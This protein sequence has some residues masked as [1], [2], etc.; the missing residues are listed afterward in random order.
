MV[1]KGSLDMFIYFYFLIY[2][3]YLFIYLFIYFKILC[4]FKQTLEV[5]E[6]IPF[7]YEESLKTH[8]AN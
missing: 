4:Q 7:I 2:L 8:K 5:Q 6:I 1:V 3:I